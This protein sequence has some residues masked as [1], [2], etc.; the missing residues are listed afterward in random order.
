[1]NCLPATT[2]E[3]AYEIL[4]VSNAAFPDRVPFYQ[5][6]RGRFN[7]GIRRASS[8]FAASTDRA[9]PT[10]AAKLTDRTPRIITYVNPSGECQ[11]EVTHVTVPRDVYLREPYQNLDHYSDPATPNQMGIWPYLEA[12]GFDDPNRRYLTIVDGSNVWNYRGGSAIVWGGGSGYGPVDDRAGA[13]NRNNADGTWIS[14][15]T[16]N[17]AADW[18]PAFDGKAP[19]RLA[20]ELAHGVGGVYGTAPHANVVGNPLHPTDCGDLLCYN[21]YDADGQDYDVCGPARLNTFRNYSDTDGPESRPAFRLDCGR[22]DYWNQLDELPSGR[23][24]GYDNSFYWGNQTPYDYTGPRFSNLDHQ[25]PPQCTYDPGGFCPPDVQGRAQAVRRRRGAAQQ[26][27]R[28]RLTHRTG[29]FSPAFSA[30]IRQRM[31]ASR[32]PSRSPSKTAVGLPDSKEVR[33]SLTTWYGLS[34]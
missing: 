10:A 15:S 12:Q 17:D 3:E 25:I 24:N 13:A 30:P 26:L 8:V 1:M 7:A 28:G 33:R 20:H 16:T 19:G 6:D 21:N 9:F 4:W 14:L 18:D 5:R 27:G 22:D 34:T 32:N 2:T 29:Q 31:P 11:P 23:W